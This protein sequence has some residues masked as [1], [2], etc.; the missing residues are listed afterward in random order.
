M[1]QNKAL[2]YCFTLNNY[3]SD[4]YSS[5]CERLGSITQYFIIGKEVGEAGT[6]HLQGYFILSKRT[7]FLTLKNQV[8]ARA[9]YEVAKG[10][11]DAN[12]IYC[13]KEGE[14]IEQGVCPP[15]GARAHKSKCAGKSRDELATEYRLCLARGRL[16]LGEFANDNPGASG[17]NGHTLFRNTVALTGAQPRDNIRVEWIWGAPGVGKSRRAHELLPEAYIK[18]PRTKWWNGYCLESDVIIDDFGPNGIDINHLLR[19]FDRYKC[20]VEIKGD[21]C[22]LL[23]DK[24]IVTSNFHPKD[25]FTD[26]M[27]AVHVQYPALERRLIINEML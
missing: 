11:P 6:P 24:F 5:I 1:S 26:N 18:D 20:Y 3:S 25:V 22:P 23:A 17:F 9:H 2:R 15:P 7:R 10:T 12:R 14:F 4:E 19:W 27:G 16:G 13:S 8:S 21:M